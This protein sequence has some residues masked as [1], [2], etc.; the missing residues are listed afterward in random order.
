MAMTDAT[1]SVLD[2]AAPDASTRL[3]LLVR[4]ARCAACIGKIRIQWWRETIEQVA[5]PGPVRRHDLAE[6][7]ARVL[8]DRGDLIA[9][10]HA[11]IDAYDDI[12][13]DHLHAGGHESGQDHQQ[14]HLAGEASLARL[15]GLALDAEA[16]PAQL[17]ALA[18][19]GEAGLAIAA[20][21]PDATQRWDAARTS[22]RQLPAVFWPAIAHLAALNPKRPQPSPFAT[23]WRIFAAVLARSL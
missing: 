13:D 10:V 4:G 7:L 1:T 19:C 16:P 6:E 3:E 5:G 2:A 17:G 20:Q 18:A 11:L 22:A 23:R 21:L 12:L 8:K 14:R 15:T 9:P